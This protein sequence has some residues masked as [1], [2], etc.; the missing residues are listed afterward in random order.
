FMGD[1][2][3]IDIH[4]HLFAPGP[5]PSRDEMHAMIRL[6]QHHG[7]DRV[8][9]L[10]NLVCGGPT[11]SIEEIQTFNTNTLNAMAAHPEFF[12]G[13]CYLNPEHPPRFLLDE[14]ERCVV[15]GDMKGIKLWIAVKAT[16][17]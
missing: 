17:K 5:I 1:P 4:T 6:A 7:I 14:I 3:R 8:V 11:P 15:K 9:A 12:I 10:S 2:W 16:D 13:F